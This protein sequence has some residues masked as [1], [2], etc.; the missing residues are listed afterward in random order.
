MS[1]EIDL[2]KVSD[3]QEVVELIKKREEIESEIRELDPN[4]LYHYELLS[5]GIDPDEVEEL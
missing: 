2:S 4:A 3:N 5:L 1:G